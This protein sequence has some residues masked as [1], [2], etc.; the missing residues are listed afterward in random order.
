[1]QLPRLRARYEAAAFLLAAYFTAFLNDAFWKRLLLAVRPDHA[2]E[3][4]FL[5]AVALLLWLL[6]S[7]MI[8]A[9]AVDYIFKPFAF[10]L[11][12][13][14]A[15]AS[16]FMREF[17]TVI[18]SGMIIN[19]LQTDKREAGDLTTWRFASYMLLWAGIPIAI[20]LQT[21][22]TRRPFLAEIKFKAF[23][24][25]TI[26]LLCVAIAYPFVMNIT[27][28]FREHSILKHEVV[29]FNIIT[30][31]HRAA[32]V[33]TAFRAP[34]TVKPFGADA[35]LDPQFVAAPRSVTVLVV[36]ETARSA[37]FSL[38]GY[39]RNTNPRLADI[40][41]VVSFN[42]VASCGTGTAQSLPCMFSGVGQARSRTTIAHEQE[43]LLDILK[44]AGFSVLWRDNQSGC[45]GICARVPTESVMTPEPKKFYEL[46][47]SYDD[48]LLAGLQQWIDGVPGHGV[49]VLHMMGSHGPAYFKRYPPEF[50]RF[51]PACKETQFSKCKTEEVV[52]AYDNTIVYTDHVL[53][54]LIKLLAK[55]DARGLATSMIY[56]SDHGESLGE[57]GLYLHG[58]PYALAP[59][60]Q[61]QVP[62]IWWLSPRFEKLSGVPTGCLRSKASASLSHDNFFHSFLGLLG[63]R[64]S[65]YDATL[66]LAALCQDATSNGP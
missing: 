32:T 9:F 19:V 11:L 14:S 24:A 56:L 22:L 10:T 5:A 36:G 4:A 53:A 20:L 58:M 59:I 13:A 44:R 48:K 27:S 40:G 37:S 61:K 6:L 49:V 8:G 16:Y 41:E 1:M 45:K 55:N 52:N 63:V 57:N 26:A 3:W 46:A 42:N 23:S 65:V 43:G 38:N 33:H 2:Y 12:T 51:S 64:S 39:G 60:E 28:V 25:A 66:D 35:K 54:E 34:K 15:A 31:V 50:E 62:W 17:G 47:I 21:R 29:P 30:G 18:N 7:L